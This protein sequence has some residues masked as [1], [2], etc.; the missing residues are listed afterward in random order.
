MKKDNR[1]TIQLTYVDR[2][3]LHSYCD[4]LDGLSQY[5]GTG[6]ELVLHSLESLDYSVIK[7]LNGFHTGRQI[8]APITDMALSILKKAQMSDDPFAPSTYYTTNQKGDPMRS[9]TLCIK[10]EN[11]RII[12]MLCI[13]FYLNTTMKD[14][15]EN[16]FPAVNPTAA[17]ETPAPMETFSS[18]SDDLIEQ[19]VQQTREEVMADSSVT[20]S[21]KNKEIIKR[22][23]HQGVYNLKDA[24]I[25]TADLLN[26]S[27]NTVYMHL[28]NIN[29]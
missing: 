29:D 19:L 28:R 14:F 16:L 25:Q 21:N 22:L 20:A 15:F 6:Y 23:H 13:N 24:V 17:A 27:K 7:V 12:G 5:L 4:M 10:G 26:I 2:Q 8:G 3:I 1:L 18:N 9:T 11:D